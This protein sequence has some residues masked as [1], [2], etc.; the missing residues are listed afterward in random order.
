LPRQ[1]LHHC[2][3]LPKTKHL[4]S[5]P[6]KDIP[7]SSQ[8]LCNHLCSSPLLTAADAYIAPGLLRSVLEE[9]AE[10]ETPSRL[11]KDVKAL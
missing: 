9:V 10:V 5:E 6:R 7:S 11:Q 4:F 1:G 2:V 3:I 8:T